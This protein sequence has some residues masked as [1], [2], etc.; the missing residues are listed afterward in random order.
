MGPLDRDNL[1]LYNQGQEP[2][3]K[4][5]RLVHEGSFYPCL[6]TVARNRAGFGRSFKNALSQG[7]QAK[8]CLPVGV[9]HSLR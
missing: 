3:P 1:Y 4:G 7:I 6:D 5:R 2:P 9:F 8:G